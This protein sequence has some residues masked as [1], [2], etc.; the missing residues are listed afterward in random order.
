MQATNAWPGLGT[1]LMGRTVAARLPN[2]KPV[3]S[4]TPVALA[5]VGPVLPP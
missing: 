2:R 1:R 3:Y 5:T 4:V